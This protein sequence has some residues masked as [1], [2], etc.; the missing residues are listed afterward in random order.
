[1]IYIEKSYSRNLNKLIDYLRTDE[2]SKRESGGV[3]KFTFLDKKKESIAISSLIQIPNKS[4]IATKYQPNETL[5]KELIYSLADDDNLFGDWH[6]HLSNRF[7]PSTEDDI[8]MF[9]KADAVK[10]KVYS[11]IITAINVALWE[12]T[13]K[14]KKMILKW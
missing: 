6:T 12:Y 5:Y 1:M 4:E 9:A 10:G 14:K 11:L 3:L 13:P 2:V 8:T 7:D